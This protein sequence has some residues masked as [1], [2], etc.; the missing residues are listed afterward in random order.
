MPSG[1]FM[2]SKSGRIV[3]RHAV[4]GLW[5]SDDA[6]GALAGIRVVD[7]TI[8]I[9]GPVATQILGD[10]GADVIKV[11]SPEGDQN[12]HIGPAR[13]PA[14]GALY[15]TMN[16]NKRSV[17]LNL[18]TAKARDVL[19]DLIE[20]ADVFVHSMRPGA[21]ERLGI[22]YA[23]VS[24]RNPRI[25]YASGP[26][27][28]PDGPNRDRPAYDDVIQGQSGIASMCERAF[29]EPRYLPTVLAD[30]LCGY[31]LASAIAMALFS[32]ERSG[33]GQEV[34]VPMLETV[35]SF[36]MLDHQWGAVFDP[37]IGG[38]GYNRLFTPYRRP[39]ATADGHMCIMASND[40]QWLRLLVAIDEPD[41]ATDPRFAKLV[42]RARNIEELYAVV[43][44]RM[45]ER[46]NAEW[47]K[48]LTDADISHAP[49]Q[50]LSDLGTDHYLTSTGF[51][52]KYQHPTEGSMIR[53]INPLQFS[54]T[55]PSRRRH[56]PR[57][58]EH[59]LEVL[60]ALGYDPGEI[61]DLSR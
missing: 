61:D 37:P 53:A 46:T 57:L 39:F 24:A 20:A 8:N 7:L 18:K 22:D 27:Y 54:A 35:L 51:F 50:Q 48:R 59:T 29:G 10:M 49:V 44:K 52:E 36:N 12:R 34:V 5:Q 15:M 26:G 16:A 56:P 3:E 23:A 31:T 47:D 21:V 42:D 2:K 41:L 19:F 4:N 6:K 58:G 11:E 40:D 25:I 14:M 17:V 45:H 33:V 55:P 9:L 60:E 30:K 28:R 1:N 38:M 43:T 13:S 32:R